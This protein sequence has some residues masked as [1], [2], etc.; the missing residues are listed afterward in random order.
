MCPRTENSNN[1]VSQHL[2]TYYLPLT[3]YHLPLTICVFYGKNQ[4]LTL[5]F[6]RKITHC[7]YV[8]FIPFDYCKGSCDHL[9]PY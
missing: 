6:S 3:T 1:N 7:V 8:R 9:T 4:A 2:T 5:F